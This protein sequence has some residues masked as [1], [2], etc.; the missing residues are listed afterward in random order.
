MEDIVKPELLETEATGLRALKFRYLIRIGGASSVFDGL[1]EVVNNN[2]T[3]YLDELCFD[4]GRNFW[5]FTDPRG[6]RC[7]WSE[8]RGK[9]FEFWKNQSN[10]VIRS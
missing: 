5:K 10:S 9:L 7:D 4:P 1:A 2:S 6:A 3:N 8:L